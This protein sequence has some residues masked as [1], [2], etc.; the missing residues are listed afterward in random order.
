MNNGF[1]LY[2]IIKYIFY[3]TSM[4]TLLTLWLKVRA[5]LNNIGRVYTKRGTDYALFLE[6]PNTELKKLVLLLKA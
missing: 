1:I 5:F 6:K 3:S 2:N 4:Y